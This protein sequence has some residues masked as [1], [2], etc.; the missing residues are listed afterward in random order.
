MNA[1]VAVLKILEDNA[2]AVGQLQCE[3]GIA[4]HHDAGVGQEGIGAVV[5]LFD[6]TRDSLAILIFD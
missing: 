2:A 1:Q 3:V 6:H 5:A 4:S